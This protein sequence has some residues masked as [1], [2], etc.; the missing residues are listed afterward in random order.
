LIGRGDEWASQADPDY[1]YQT[2]FTFADR[3]NTTQLA[4]LA[5]R[6]LSG[7]ITS[8]EVV[9]SSG[10]YDHVIEMKASNLDPQLKSSSLGFELGG[11]DFILGGMVGNS[12]QIAAQGGQAP[13]YQAEFLGT[14]IW[15]FMASQTPALVLPDAVDQNY[16]GQRSQTSVEFNDGTVFD[17]TGD[18]RLDSYNLQFSNNLITGERRLG[19]PIVDSTD[20]NSPA[21]PRQL[22]RGER[23]LAASIGVY[24]ANDKRGYL[25]HLANTEI[26]NFKM[27]SSG[28]REI[29][30]SGFYHEFEVIIPSAVIT[31]P[32][33]GGDRK[34]IITL[35]F[36]PLFDPTS[37]EDGIF[38][39]RVRNNSTTL[40]V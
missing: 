29:G 16:V 11:F 36:E 3:L 38:K 31:T 9:A 24:V 25:A 20:D 30:T 12:L 17:I 6:M 27:T 18:G 22:T 1:A 8:T 37:G 33:L 15:D 23:T 2:A 35:N 32:S 19:D 14:G 40:D 13:N 34:G 39:I 5:A 10:V 28:N 26:T 21:Y 4:L 7:T